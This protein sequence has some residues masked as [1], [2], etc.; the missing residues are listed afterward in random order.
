MQKII[1]MK[2]AKRQVN[3]INYFALAF[4]FFFQVQALANVMMRNTLSAKGEG[5]TNLAYNAQIKNILVF[6]P[7]GWEGLTSSTTHDPEYPQNGGKTAYLSRDNNSL[8]YQLQLISELGTTTAIA[9]LLMNDGDSN[10]SGFG[11]CW[12]GQWISGRNCNGGEWRTPMAVYRDVKW[13]AWMKGVQVAPYISLM[14]YEYPMGT[15]GYRI[16]PKLEAM[17]NELRPT[18]DGASLRTEDGRYVV[19]VDSLPE[20]AGLTEDDKNAVTWYMNSQKDIFWVNNIITEKMRPDLYSSHN[21]N[22]SA[23]TSDRSG[24][25]QDYLKNIWGEQFLWWFTAKFASTYSESVDPAHN[26]PEDIRLKWLN[27]SPHDP[28]RYPV[29]ISQWNEYAE[30]LIYEPSTKSGTRNYD[31]LKWMLSRQP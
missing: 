30:Y 26:I 27:I 1:F 8:L 6:Q 4:I 16:R 11:T 15:A 3:K 5:G 12:N 21:M 28:A 19:V 29:I 7:G 10:A 2:N 13:A 17:L 23:A 25:I 14:N 24:T 9:V 22:V 31:Y 20:W 18:F